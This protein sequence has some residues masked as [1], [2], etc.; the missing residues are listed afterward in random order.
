MEHNQHILDEAI[1]KYPELK[2]IIIEGNDILSEIDSEYEIIDIYDV[3]GKLYYSA[4]YSEEIPS[5]SQE[6]SLFKETIKNIQDKS[7]NIWKK[8]GKFETQRQEFQKHLEENRRVRRSILDLTSRCYP[9]IKDL[10]EEAHT[11]LVEVDPDYI[12]DQIKEKY[13]T[14]RYYASPSESSYFDDTYTE[15]SEKIY[16]ITQDIEYRGTQIWID[17][18]F[19]YECYP[20]YIGRK[21][22]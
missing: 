14:L 8:I 6:E 9:D 7:N 5:N 15:K 3:Y 21:K 19:Y 2:D 13:G 17:N 11:R 4:I 20:N 16:E 18:G 12:I 10:L 22:D 1:K